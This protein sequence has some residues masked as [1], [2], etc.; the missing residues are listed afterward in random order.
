MLAS[1]LSA[2]GAAVGHTPSP[3]LFDRTER[4]LLDGHPIEHERYFQRLCEVTRGAEA[5][6]LSPTFFVTA[7]AASML[8]F[9]AQRVD[10]GIIEA[11]LGGVDDATNVLES[12]RAAVL[13]SI[14]YDHMKQ[15]GATLQEIAE[16]KAGIAR[17]G[18]PMFVGEV[19]EEAR[20]AILKRAEAAG[21]PVEFAGRD[22]SWDH[23]RKILSG[24]FGERPLDLGGLALSGTFQRRNA[25]LAARTAYALGISPAAVHRG[26]ETVAW[27]GRFETFSFSSETGKKTILFDVAHNE[28]GTRML[29]DELSRLTPRPVQ[30]V[31]I[32]SMLDR[33]D[34]RGALQYLASLCERMPETRFRWICTSSLHPHVRP[35]AELA[36]FLTSAGAKDVL[37]REAPESAFRE[38]LEIV[39][40]TEDGDSLVVATGSTYLVS[41]LRP[42]CSRL[43][44]ETITRRDVAFFSH[45]G[46]QIDPFGP[47]A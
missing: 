42:L 44:F 2:S 43:P 16:K 17:S 11:G 21:A 14:G 34:Y 39:R 18:V 23:E 24:R 38:A 32:L 27:P 47:M 7:F 31:I 37:V 3:H 28:E 19:P 13:T 9:L 10:W 5:I 35:P 29:A 30:I 4:C 15:L 46:P 26:L 12:T 40:S 6:G 25:I 1:I 33:K 22:F 41:K 8:E 45:S 20:A 36:E